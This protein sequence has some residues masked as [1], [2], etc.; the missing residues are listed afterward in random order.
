MD[1]IAEHLR[2]TL[3]DHAR[4]GFHVS[5][6]PLHREVVGHVRPTLLALL[7]A[8]GIVLLIAC[9]NVANLLLVRARGRQKEIAV[10]A[11]LGGAPSRIARQL[12]TESL[13]LGAVGAAAGIL[14]GYAGIRFL[15]AL[16]PAKFPRLESI[17]IDGTV[18]AYT[19]GASVAATIVFGLAPTYRAM[20]S[21]LSEALTQRSQE[22]SSGARSRT[23]QL[24]IVAEVA[25]SLVLLVGAGLLM[26]S[27][28]QL[29]EV[30]PG[31]DADDLLTFSVSLP[32]TF[33]SI[34]SPGSSRTS[35]MPI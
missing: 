7:G 19:L 1:G 4:M 27:F 3:A 28:V 18:L 17:A 14:L 33:R 35:D 21:N 16:Q 11:A 34:E 15:L 31:F 12:F 8:V 20:R 29:Q 23:S 25:L 26:R 13:L 32:S 6:E 24:L 10:R 22:G 5:V 2:S 30:R 9:V